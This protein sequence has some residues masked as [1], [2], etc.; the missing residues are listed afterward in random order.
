MPRRGRRGSRRSSRRRRRPA[1]HS[2]TSSPLS[3]PCSRWAGSWVWRSISWLQ[4]TSTLAGHTTST[5]RSPAAA[6]V[7]GD[8]QGLDGL[9][10]PHLVA[11]HRPL[12]H[13]RELRPER[14]VA[15]QL[16]LQQAGVERLGL[17]PGDDVVRD[18]PVGRLGRRRE[19]TDLGEQLVVGD[20]SAL[21]VGPRGVEAGGVGLEGGDRGVDAGDELASR[22]RAGRRARP[23]PARPAPSSSLTRRTCG[24]CWCPA[25]RGAAARR[26][27][28][29]ARRRR[30]RSGRRACR[31]PRPRGGRGVPG[32]APRAG[33]RRRRTCGRRA[34]APLRARRPPA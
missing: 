33:G 26:W 14:L 10:E 6:E 31:P 7:A 30:L 34:A 8:G 22:L 1:T 5:C 29:R 25:A 9:P 24:A 19:P 4:F 17:D 13:E 15:A 12:L 16:D 21:V 23:T 32:P 11:D 3:E 28:G 27:R 20:R 18:E 2:A